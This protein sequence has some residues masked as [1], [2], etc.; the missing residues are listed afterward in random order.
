MICVRILSTDVRE[1]I[2]TLLL[3]EIGLHAITDPR[4]LADPG[5]SFLEGHSEW[6]L[7]PQPSNRRCHSR[8]SS[9]PFKSAQPLE[10]PRA[11][12]VSLVRR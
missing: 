6:T 5:W 8:T 10:G 4:G 9:P 1:L 3:T 12:P 7:Q 2:S 11:N